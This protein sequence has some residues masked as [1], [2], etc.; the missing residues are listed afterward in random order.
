M[1]VVLVCALTPGQETGFGFGFVGVVVGDDELAG[2]SLEL[3]DV[4]GL[5]E[6]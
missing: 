4:L 2:G 3:A 6:E 1:W 5:S